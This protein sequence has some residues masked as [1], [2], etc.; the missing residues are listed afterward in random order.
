MAGLTEQATARIGT[1]SGGQRQRLYFALA[2][3]GDPD[4]LFLDE[5]TVGMDVE[6]RR[7]F[8]ASIQTLAGA[9][10]T[11]VFTTHYLRE[12]EELAR[13]IIVIDRGAVIAD[14][15]PQELKARVPGKK[16]TLVA[17]RPF[18]PADLDGLPARVLSDERRAREPAQQ[19]AGRGAARA[20][21]PRRGR[22]GPGGDR[23]GS[24]GGVPRA[25]PA[26]RGRVVTGA[27]T[28][29]APLGRMLLAQTWSELRIRWRI[30]AFSVT[31]V[32]LPV[33]FFTFFGL[34][35]A[36]QTLPNGMSLGAY[37]V[38]SFAAYSVGSVMVF[39]FGIGVAIERGQ[40]VDLLMR[41]TPL[42]PV[43][44]ILAKV[45]NALFYALLSLVVLIVYAVV[46]GGIRQDLTVWLDMIARLLAG[47]VPFIALGFAIGY[48]CGPNVA[49][50]VANLVYLPLTFASGL[51]MPLNQLPGF[52]RVIAPYLPAYHYGQLGW[53]ARRRQHRAPAGQ[54]RLA[55]RLH[56]CSSCS[57]RSAPT[58]TK[59]P[60]SSA[61]LGSGLELRHF[62]AGRRATRRRKCRNSRPDPI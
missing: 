61:S 3:C 41:A 42:P 49:P 2:I 22:G 9:G 30:P 58:A 16:I 20:V 62:H 27:G 45:L 34:P 29:V 18:A 11:I 6:A 5:P 35:Y 15:S 14:A 44:A 24:R 54:P 28:A 43:I 21:P 19:R 38:A 39:G 37:L 33:L 36:K 13:R 10:K 32:A 25:D 52:V 47:S 59:N 48:L 40:K 7:A 17:G 53:S 4:I 50:A 31:I 51:F 1:L 55:R 60:A 56:R 23:R 57:S 12:A 8:T 26:G 46:V